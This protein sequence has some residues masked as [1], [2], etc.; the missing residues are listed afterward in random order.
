MNFENVDDIVQFRDRFD[1]YVF[2]DAKGNESQ[3]MV[4]LA[5]FPKVPIKSKKDPKCGTIENG[6]NIFI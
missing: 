2:V 1:G 3:A 4:E 5:P 6:E